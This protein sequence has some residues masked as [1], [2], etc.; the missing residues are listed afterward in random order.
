M[1]GAFTQNA[2]F[3]PFTAVPNRT[4]LTAGLATPP[5][6]G[7]DTPAQQNPLAAAAP[8]ATVPADKQQVAAQWDEWKSHQRL[9][10]PD[11]KPDFA[12]P[13][14]MNHFTWYQA[15]D[16]KRPYPG[17]DKIFAPEDVPGAYIPSSE[18]D[19]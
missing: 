8:S 6:C 19:G 7:V 11:A 14:Q 10:G 18:S 5:A 13:A 1:R 17:E 12:N 15:H 16:W 9:T 4:S 3:T 2:D